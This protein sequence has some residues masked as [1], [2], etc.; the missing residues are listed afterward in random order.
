M[1]WPH[2]TKNRS[3]LLAGIVPSVSLTLSTII[4]IAKYSS[5]PDLTNVYT[6]TMRSARIDVEHEGDEKEEHS[7][8]RT[9]TTTTKRLT[10]TVWTHAS[11]FRGRT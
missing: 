5:Q 2:G 11:I 9:A 1:Y 6:N 8:T 7:L 3:V 4:I 10:P